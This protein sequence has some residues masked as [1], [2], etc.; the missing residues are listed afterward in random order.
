MDIRLARLNA[1]SAK[2]TVIFFIPT[3]NEMTP[4]I[5]AFDVVHGGVIK[6]SLKNSRFMGE[7]GQILHLPVPQG[8][9]DGV[10]LVGLGPVARAKSG[11][12]RQMGISVGQLIDKH[13][14]DS[15]TLVMEP[16]AKYKVAL[17]RAVAE[18]IEG[19]EL[20]FYRFDRFK[21][22]QKLHEAPFFKELAVMA[23][24]ATRRAVEDELPFLQ[25]QTAGANLTR[26]LVNLPANVCN[27]EYLAKEAQKLEKLGVKVEILGQKELEKHG[28]RLM[29]SVNQASENEPRLLIMKWMGAGKEQPSAIVGKGVTFDTGGYCI[30]TPYDGMVGMKA[31]M[32]G[33]AAVIGTLHTLAAAK[34]KVNVIGVAGCVENMI[35]DEATRPSDIVTAYNGTTVEILNTDAEGRL[36]LADAMAY[37]ID[38]E[39]PKEVIDIATLTGACMMA[40]GAHYA[41]LFSNTDALASKL[42]E[43]GKLSGE[44]LWRLPIGPEYHRQL[45]S[46]NADV[47]NIGPGYAGASTAA[48][49]LEK[50]VGKTPWAHL[51]IAGVAMAGKVPGVTNLNGAN[52]FGVRLFSRY[53]SLNAVPEGADG[54]P[55]RR[56]R[57]RK[58]AALEVA[59]KV[60]RGRGRPRKTA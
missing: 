47:A 4:E 16:L 54:A 41:G 20:A 24:T 14:L 56:G 27:A 7:P 18:F 2:N 48:C 1:S 40:L 46:E 44:R 13:G 21:T 19:M 42:Q 39:N 32:A 33:A 22:K 58:A 15:A 57:P 45:K 31:D 49:F 6:K 59:P 23:D 37:I 9:V 34:M 53:F 55:R 30:K 43:A 38:K 52:G 28:L 11:D 36:V 12:F 29:L 10:I 51:D 35:S 17:P 25:A 8:A 3:R 26:E 50:F 5:Q 60:K